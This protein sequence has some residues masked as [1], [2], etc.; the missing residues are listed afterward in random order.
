[1]EKDQLDGLIALKLV[2][3][4]RSFT[5]AA[6]ELRISGPGISKM[7]SQLEKRMGTTLLTRTTRT[8]SL[9]E[10]G[11]SFLEEVGPAIDQILSAQENARSSALKPSGVLRLN[12]PGIFYP[13]YLA[14]FI[15]SYVKKYPEVTVD[16]ISEDQTSD[17]FERGFD[18]GVR[19]SDILAKDLVAL[20]LFGPIKFVTVASPKYLNKM[21]R[22]KH[23]K[24]LLSH[25]CIRQRFGTG[26]SVYDK[27]EFEDKGKEFEVRV[28]GSLIF[29]D[30]FQIL[31]A[32][33]AGVGIIY[34]TF[35][36]VKESV[37]SKK[38]EVILNPFHVK[39]TGYY[40]YYP[41]TSQVSPKLRA[42]IDLFKEKRDKNEN[43]KDY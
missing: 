1:M 21:G 15:S 42:F 37:E 11:K 17:V 16:I 3:E 39:S 4:L 38:L 33:L 26:A 40:L 30:S 10:A 8:V 32:A 27:W 31:H 7:I 19:H 20:K 5:A 34:T 35:E 36:A 22:P 2:S 43:K 28:S 13:A 29:N 18:A 23:P 12:M 14:P 41:K 24:E 25:N 9:T 6:E